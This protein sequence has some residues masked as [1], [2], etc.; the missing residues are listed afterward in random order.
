MQGGDHG[1]RVAVIGSGIF[2]GETALF[3]AAAGKSVILVS[4]EEAVMA[5]A[6]PLIAATTA[7]RF[8]EHG[9]TTVTGVA[10]RGRPVGHLEVAAE[11]RAPPRGTVRSARLGLGWTAPE[12]V[13]LTVGDTWDAFA[14]RLLVA[15]ATRIA[16]RL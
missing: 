13:A 15:R 12:T 1:E 3:L 14:Q 2:A 7:H 16:R 11:G 5:D 10:L 4:P 6:H 8:A 9:G